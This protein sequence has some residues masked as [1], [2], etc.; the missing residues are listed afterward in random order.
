MFSV[1]AYRRA[2][3][4]VL[5]RMNEQESRMLQFQY[6]AP[7]R[8]ITAGDLAAALGL[9]HYSRAN[10]IYGGIG[11]KVA[12]YLG[13]IQYRHRNGKPELFR[14]L[15]DGK[16][17]PRGYLWTMNPNLARALEELGV[18]SEREFR[19]P[20]QVNE[21]VVYKEGA[22]SRIT[23]NAYERNPQAR[24]RCIEY[25]GARCFVCSFDFETTYGELGRGYIHVHHLRRLS[26]IGKEY[27]V[28][29]IADL[30]PICPNCHA[31]IH[32]R[33]PPYSIEEMQTMLR[34]RQSPV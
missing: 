31:M 25:Y 29:P 32:T 18:V 20:E 24:K 13:D 21:G 11:R 19:F 7:A 6:D 30:R 27:N 10:L 9:S 8:T 12:P 26:D 2:F 4:A 23:I 22:A 3:A 34:I 5:Q 28:D 16:F 1:E 33:T 15:A 17:D 14:Y